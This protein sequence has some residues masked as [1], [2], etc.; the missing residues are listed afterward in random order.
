MWYFLAGLIVGLFAGGSALVFIRRRRAG[1]AA[2]PEPPD[3]ELEEL[4]RLAGELAHEIRNPL[5]TLKV[6]LQLVMEDLAAV[7]DARESE[8]I[9]RATRKLEVIRKETDRLEQILDGFLRYV[10]RPELEPMTVDLNEL[11]GDMIDF[12]GPQAISHGIAV[13]PRLCAGK[14]MCRLDP[15]MLKQVLLNLFINAQQAMPNGGEL[16]IRTDRSGGD[17][18]IEVVDTGNGIP[19]DRIGHIFDAYYSTRPD[20]SGLGLSTARKII[21]A[22]GGRIDVQSEAGNG[23]TFTIRLPRQIQ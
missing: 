12:Y 19:E 13:G 6:N 17:A 9:R 10:A 1:A 21:L 22:H 5:S 16:A 7:K 23:A 15:D 4:A 18:V 20:G 2:R 8:N 11:V 14:L 3:H